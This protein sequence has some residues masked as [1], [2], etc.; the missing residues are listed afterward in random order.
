MPNA[1]ATACSEPG[2]PDAAVDRGRC[3]R[4]RRTTTERGYGREHQLDRAAALPG[5]KCEACG[6]TRNLQRDHRIPR[7]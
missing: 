2:C 4:H 6:C 1:A 7:S 5:A 3:A